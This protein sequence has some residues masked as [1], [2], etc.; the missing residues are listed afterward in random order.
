MLLS[1]CAWHSRT[2]VHLEWKTGAADEL[3][4]VQFNEQAPETAG[5]A[6]I[7]NAKI[8]SRLAMRAEKLERTRGI[9]NGSGE[10]QEP[11]LERRIFFLEMVEGSRP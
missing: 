10:I 11:P 9:E 2:G 7:T 5:A 1:C 4:V 3:A 8:F 6:L